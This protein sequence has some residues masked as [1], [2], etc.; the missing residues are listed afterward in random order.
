MHAYL[1]KDTY[2]AQ[3]PLEPPVQTPKWQIV[4]FVTSSASTSC[5]CSAG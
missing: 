2:T 4:T 3:M 5:S 1:L